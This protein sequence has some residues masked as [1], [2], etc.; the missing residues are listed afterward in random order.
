MLLQEGNK[1]TYHTITD[2]W[3]DTG[4]PEDVLHANK[5]ILKKIQGDFQGRKEGDP[6]IS[7]KAIIG[8]GSIIKGNSKIS[9]SVIIGENCIIDNACIGSYSSLGNNSTVISS[10]IKNSI[11]ME[12]CKIEGNLSIKDSIIARNS[13]INSKNNE[14]KIFLLGE[15]TQIE[16]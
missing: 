4:T 16:F 8:K 7:D 6:T 5:E 2:Y 1:I 13:T 15:G 14:E 10:K 9:D 11:I 12:N 3:K